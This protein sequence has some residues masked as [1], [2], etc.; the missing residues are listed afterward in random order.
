MKTAKNVVSRVAEHHYHSSPIEGV[1]DLPLAVL[2]LRLAAFHK[3]ME[4]NA[5]AAGKAR[6][7]SSKAIRRRFK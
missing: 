1:R 7:G 6:G 4:A 2:A 5:K 3:I